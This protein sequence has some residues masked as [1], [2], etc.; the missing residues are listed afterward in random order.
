MATS[1]EIHEQ[2]ARALTLGALPDFSG[3]DPDEVA[4]AFREAFDFLNVREDWLTWLRERVREL[5]DDTATLEV[6]P[7]DQFT[8][9]VKGAAVYLQLVKD[10]QPKRIIITAAEPYV[11][12]D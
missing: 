12:E 5:S 7:K 1:Q 11:I 9:E 10:G 4:T 8:A 3:F 2:A 6:A